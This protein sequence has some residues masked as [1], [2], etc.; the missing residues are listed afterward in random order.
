M[1]SVDADLV[2]GLCQEPL[3]NHQGCVSL[4]PN[5]QMWKSWGF[6]FFPLKYPLKRET[7]GTW[8]YC[9]EASGGLANPPALLQRACT[10]IARGFQYQE[11]QIERKFLAD[12]LG[13]KRGGESFSSSA[14]MK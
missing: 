14:A 5:F 7:A 11:K 4:N 1:K 10:R 13:V 12:F 9:L 2:L 3:M 6:F 8:Q